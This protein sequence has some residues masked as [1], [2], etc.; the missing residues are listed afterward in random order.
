M[1]WRGSMPLKGSSSSSSD[2]SWTRADAILTR[3]RMPLEYVEILRSCAYS[4]STV[5]SA[6]C[7]AL[8]PRPCNSALATTNSRPVRKSYIASR[9]GTMPMCR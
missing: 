7:A 8:A 4:I 3:W 6:F 1:R 9:S 2:G 5:A